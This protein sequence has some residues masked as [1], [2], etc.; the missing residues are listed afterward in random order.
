VPFPAAWQ[1]GSRLPG[2]AKWTIDVRDGFTKIRLCGGPNETKKDS[3]ITT[4]CNKIFSRFKGL[5]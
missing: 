4:R 2:A 5:R 3:S 1:A